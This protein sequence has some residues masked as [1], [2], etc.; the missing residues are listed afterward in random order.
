MSWLD[1]KMIQFSKCKKSFDY[2]IQANESEGWAPFTV[3][4]FSVLL[5][6]TA[7]PWPFFS[8]SRASVRA[9]VPLKMRREGNKTR[10]GN[11]PGL[12]RMGMK[13]WGDGKWTMKSCLTCCLGMG[14]VPMVR[15]DSHNWGIIP[16]S[17]S[18]LEFLNWT[19]KEGGSQTKNI[20]KK[21]VV[22][23]K[24]RMCL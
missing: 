12:G 16:S 14:A 3:L 2:H 22:S 15:K 18:M 13:G 19:I 24:L 20:L 8:V 7:S 9:L 6:P 17:L 1:S 5:Q 10:H 4:V 11:G 23:Y 21:C